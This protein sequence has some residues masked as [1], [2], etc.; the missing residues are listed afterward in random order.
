MVIIKTHKKKKKV[1]KQLEFNFEQLD[2]F[3]H[4]KPRSTTN[5]KIQ[6]H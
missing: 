4:S 6:N 1:L 5:E 3:L 2:L